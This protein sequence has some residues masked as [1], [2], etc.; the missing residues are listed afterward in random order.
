MDTFHSFADVLFSR[1]AWTSMQAIVL[2]GT[3]WLAGRVFPRLPAAARSTLWWL[4]GV[5]LILGLAIV[6]PVQLPLLPATPDGASLTTAS[7]QS[8]IVRIAS[9][10]ASRPASA[11][12]SQLSPATAVS[13]TQPVLSLAFVRTHGPLALMCLWLAGVLVQLVLVARDWRRMRAVLRDTVPLHDPM[14]QSL[15]A[16]QVRVLKLRRAPI[17]R[18]SP[19]ILSPQ[20]MGLWRPTILLPA[21]HDLTAHESSLALAHELTHL[22]RGDLW[23]SWIPTIAQRLFFFHPLVAWAVREYALSREAA[24][25]AQVLQQTGAMPQAYGRLLLRL[26]VAH[27]MSSG[28]A[29]ASSSFQ[30]L[31]RRLTMLQQTDNLPRQRARGWL[32]IGLIAAAGVLPYR[33]TASSPGHANVV[34]ATADSSSATQSA[35]TP[36][37]D[38]PLA[39]CLLYTSPSPRD[40]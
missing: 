23:M 33:V 14:L 13:A 36:P 22:R 3:V 40:S 24:C 32:L 16:E 31:K 8:A 15:C 26:G 21:S 11:A 19:D 2:I 10:H 5:Q 38:A 12:T 39:P 29:G 30:N 1:L 9:A 7:P 6:T 25:D 18:V 27:P 20:V 17:L 34:Q 28:L 4:I 37:P 35:S